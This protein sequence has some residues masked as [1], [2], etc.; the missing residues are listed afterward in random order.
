[1]SDAEWDATE[2]ID[3]TN[4]E[5][6]SRMQCVFVNTEQP[7]KRIRRLGLLVA[8]KRDNKI[9]VS[10]M[11]EVFY[12]HPDAPNDAVVSVYQFIS[13]KVPMGLDTSV[14]FVCDA[15]KGFQDH[16]KLDSVHKG[17]MIERG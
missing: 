15:M 16:V 17:T 11:C 7:P 3:S 12:P 8:S 1:M 9:Q 6:Q 5:T 4:E 14:L 2:R 13:C 10:E